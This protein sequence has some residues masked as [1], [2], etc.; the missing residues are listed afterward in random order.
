MS[1]PAPSS[2]SSSTASPPPLL[3]LPDAPIRRQWPV[4]PLLFVAF[5]VFG[6]VASLVIVKLIGGPRFG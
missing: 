1:L 5:V 2:S 6:V 4:L 3:K